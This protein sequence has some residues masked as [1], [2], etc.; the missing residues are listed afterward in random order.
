MSKLR[1][2]RGTALLSAVGGLMILQLM[3]ASQVFAYC[4]D[5]VLEPE[6]GEQCD[7]GNGTMN[8]GCSPQ[9]VIEAWV[10][11]DGVVEGTESCDDGNNV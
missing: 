8:D 1:E 9:C 11:G 3:S 6:L 4:Q 2:R 7:D 10:C 5:G